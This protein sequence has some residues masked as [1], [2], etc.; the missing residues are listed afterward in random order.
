MADTD[1]VLAEL[2][3]KFPEGTNDLVPI[4]F[5]G[6]LFVLRNPSSGEYKRFLAEANDT[7]SGMSGVATHNLF[8]ATCVYPER[9]AVETALKRYPGLLQNP[10]VQGAIK[11]LCGQADDIAGKG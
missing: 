10:K 1:T 4:E 3:T 7:A 2:R 11:Y 8:V 5:R 6:L 9:P